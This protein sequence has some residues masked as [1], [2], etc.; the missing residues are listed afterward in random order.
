MKGF[1]VDRAQTTHGG[2]VSTTQNLYV[3]MGIQVLRAGDGHFAQN[4]NVGL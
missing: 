4:V 1:A 3:T 2:V